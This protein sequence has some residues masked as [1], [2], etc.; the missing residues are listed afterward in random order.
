MNADLRTS[1]VLAALWLAATVTLDLVLRSMVPGVEVLT[2]SLWIILVLSAVLAVGVSVKGWWRAVGYVPPAAWRDTR[3]L[4]VPAIITLFPLVAG[5]RP[6]GAETYAILIAGYTLTGFAEET[7]FR[8]VL[9]KLLERRSV[10]AIAG[11]TAALFGLVHLGNIVVRGEVAIIVAQAVGAAAFGF[12]FAA[13]R[14][15]TGTVVPLVLL[16][17]LHD[18]FLQMGTLPLVPVAVAQDVLLFALGVYLLRGMGPK[19]AAT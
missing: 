17:M 2:A 11:I 13:L 12:G 6:L 9:M 5:V 16:H 19:A 14:L 4:L 3:W 8:G 15:R 10:W 1:V 7:L 18:L